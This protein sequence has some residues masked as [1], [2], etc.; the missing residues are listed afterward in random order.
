MC[1]ELTGCRHA[2]GDGMRDCSVVFAGLDCEGFRLPTE[3]EWEYAA[4]AGLTTPLT[5]N[6]I[7][8]TAWHRSN[9]DEHTHPVGQLQPNPWGFYDMLGNV[10]EW[11]SDTP[12]PYPTDDATDPLAAVDDQHRIRRGGSYRSF[13]LSVRFADRSDAFASSR[14]REF[15]TGFRLARTASPSQT[16]ENNAANMVNPVATDVQT[17]SV[18]P[19]ESNHSNVPDQFMIDNVAVDL[20]EENEYSAGGWAGG[21]VEVYRRETDTGPCRG[22]TPDEP[23]HIL[24]VHQRSF[25]RISV[26]SRSD[27]TLSIEGPDGTFCSDDVHGF[28]PQ[29]EAELSTGTYRIWVGTYSQRAAQRSPEYTIHFILG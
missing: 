19:T 16:V 4:R 15:S 18:A 3:A 26:A 7:T 2:P 25:I 24:V 21:S 20:A 14:G 6:Q 27:T 10:Q 17:E 23:N 8:S 1:Y 13:Y 28:N 5:H 22:W 11:V 9:A 29:I 12:S